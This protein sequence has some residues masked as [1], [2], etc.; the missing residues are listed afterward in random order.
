MAEPLLA[1][2]LGAAPQPVGNVSQLYAPHSAYRCAGDDDWI[3]LAVADDRQWRR[4][5]DIVPDL[6]LLASLGFTQ[7]M[8]QRHKI[9]DILSVW[10]L[11]QSAAAAARELLNA[12]IPA[13]ALATSRDL[14]G[15]DHLR[16]RG[17]WDPYGAGVLPGLP[18]RA[19]FGRIFS[20]APG[21]GVDTDA[22]LRELIDMSS[23]EI[24]ELRRSGALG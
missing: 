1:E 8:E 7:R 18:W 13:A 21:L 22:V 20:P 3:G 14:V 4:L 5:C 19:S 2:Q 16:E 12:G 24:A 11:R 9:D 17:F 6:S 15:C 10:A 23:D